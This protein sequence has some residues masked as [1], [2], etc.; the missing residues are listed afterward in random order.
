LR[1]IALRLVLCSA[2]L[3]VGTVAMAQDSKPLAANNS[4][5]NVR[6]RAPGAMTA[7]QQSSVK[8]DVELTREIR[9]SVVKDDQLSMMAHNVKIVSSSGAVTL[10]GP[11]K[12]REEK[13]IIAHKA[14]AIAGKGMVD[15][16]LEV[17][18]QN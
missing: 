9:R 1:T 11:V 3:G 18:G 2:L 15:N 10:R 13:T 16:Q 8:S 12:T 14:R 6:D 17:I 7:G 4:G 5:V